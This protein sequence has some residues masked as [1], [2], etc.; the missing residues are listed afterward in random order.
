MSNLP[1]FDSHD[2]LRQ[3]LFESL[4]AEGF[5]C[6]MG[7]PI[8]ENNLGQVYAANAL[9]APASTLT[10][11]EDAIKIFHSIAIANYT[12]QIVSGDAQFDYSRVIEFRS[13]DL[14]RHATKEDHIYFYL[15]GVSRNE[16]QPIKWQYD[17]EGKLERAESESTEQDD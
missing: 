5:K 1:L 17:S 12:S 7:I 4:E 6:V 3:M 15:R 14:C 10:T 8:H 9:I 11:K 2:E 13:I 16:S